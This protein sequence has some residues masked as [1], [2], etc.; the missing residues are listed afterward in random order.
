MVVSAFSAK[1][2][3]E[4]GILPSPT[5][6]AKALTKCGFERVPQQVK[7]KGAPQRVWLKDTERGTKTREELNRWIRL[8]LVRPL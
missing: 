5:T 2:A 8:N 6:L 3:D 1:L 7:I 4:T